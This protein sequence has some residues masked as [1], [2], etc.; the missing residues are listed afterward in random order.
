M[1]LKPYRTKLEQLKGQRD[2]YL[3]L[4]ANETKRNA[5]LKKEAIEIEQAQDILQH[6]AKKTQE[7]LS[8]HIEQLVT[9]A[10][11]YVM[12]DPYEFKVEWDIKN[13]RTQC[14]FSFFRGGSSFNPMNDS[15]GTALDI[16]SI[17]LRP[18]MWSLGDPRSAPVFLLDE[19]TKHVSRDLREKSS[20]FLKF[21]VDKLGIQIITSTHEDE[22]ITGSDRTFEIVKENDYS[23]I[24]RH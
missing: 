10:L 19:P 4:L 13:N 14:V 5:L 22:L 7:T 1:N 3:T 8:I 17:A 21:L 16:A 23:Q 18:S 20:E 6:V 11:E 15:G 2:S 9:T 12:P 24:K